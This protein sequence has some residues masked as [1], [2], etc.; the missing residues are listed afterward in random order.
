M[1]DQ[2]LATDVVR[3]RLSFHITRIKM[4]FLQTERERID[5]LLTPESKSQP[6]CVRIM[7]SYS[8]GQSFRLYLGSN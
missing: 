8:R 3:A 6:L 5:E 7:K 1:P 2:L 4:F